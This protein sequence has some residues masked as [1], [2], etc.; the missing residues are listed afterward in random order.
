[1]AVNTIPEK[2]GGLLYKLAG[3][4][5]A[6]AQAAVCSALVHIPIQTC[7]LLVMTGELY[8]IQS[9]HAIDKGV[10]GGLVR[11][12]IAGASKKHGA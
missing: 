6:C 1:M 11:S 2:P 10:H 5:A 3:G 7:V 12:C 8:I 9:L 4:G